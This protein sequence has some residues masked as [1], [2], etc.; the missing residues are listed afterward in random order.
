MARG[1]IVLIPFPF[2]DFSKTKI[3]PVLCLTDKL[4]SHEHI[5][6]AFITSNLIDKELETDLVLSENFQNYGLQVSSKIQL[7]RLMTVSSSVIQRELGLLNQE[8]I[9]QVDF[10]LKKV[11]NL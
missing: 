5:I 9:K 6:V 11:F 8:L 3:R 2:D 10:K 4:G 1:K 7:H